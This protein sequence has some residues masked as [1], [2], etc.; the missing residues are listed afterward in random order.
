VIIKTRKNEGLKTMRMKTILVFF[1]VVIGVIVFGGTTA[2]AQR[3][4]VEMVRRAVEKMISDL[5]ESPTAELLETTCQVGQSGG[6]ARV[7]VLE[8]QIQLNS[9]REQLVDV[10]AGLRETNTILLGGNEWVSSTI[11]SATLQ[12]A[13][14]PFRFRISVPGPADTAQWL[15]RGLMLPV[16]ELYESGTGRL[17]DAT[18]AVVEEPRYQVPEF[19]PDVLGRNNVKNLKGYEVIWSATLSPPSSGRPLVFGGVVKNPAG[20]K[21]NILLQTGLVS[22]F[23]FRHPDEKWIWKAESRLA[24]TP[25]RSEV[26]FEIEVETPAGIY[27][28][29]GNEL[30]VGDVDILTEAEQNRI[31]RQ[32]QQAAER[33]KIAPE[34]IRVGQGAGFISVLEAGYAFSDPGSRNNRAHFEAALF[35]SAPNPQE[36][37]VVFGFATN[38]DPQLEHPEAWHFSSEKMVEI[39]PDK[40]WQ[41]NEQIRCHIRM[42]ELIEQGRYRPFILVSPVPSQLE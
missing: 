16:V 36:V 18:M 26:P 30:Y 17:V 14:A 24:M 12:P 34:G 15:R 4:S 2:S 23:G 10:K 35:S 20:K 21:E 1:S 41:L 27:V 13:A 7:M 25:E 29:I 8:G 6:G 28:G 42:H 11:L 19:D 5:P 9:T 39:E 33:K 3:G 32:K 38:D 37:R 31:N 22:R 40:A